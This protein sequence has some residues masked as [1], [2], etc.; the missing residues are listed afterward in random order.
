MD[1][2][3]KGFMCVSVQS[4][5]TERFPCSHVADSSHCQPPCDKKKKKKK[6]ENC[7]PKNFKKYECASVDRSYTD[8]QIILDLGLAASE[9]ELTHLVIT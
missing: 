1:N 9:L 8:S 7:C 4:F 6:K 3:N 5:E 2:P